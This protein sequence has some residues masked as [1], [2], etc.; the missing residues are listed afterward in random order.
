MLAMKIMQKGTL[1]QRWVRREISN[2]QYIMELNA[3][4]GRSLLD[5]SHYPVFPWVI[6]DFS[7]DELDLFDPRTFRDL[8][9]PMGA[10]TLIRL[11]ELK[12]RSENLLDDDE[13][14]DSTPY[15]LYGSHYSTPIGTVAHFL[16]R[17]DPWT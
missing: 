14:I 11:Q 13:S 9:R 3:L 10:L 12:A 7:S 8:Q 6:G 4:A 15:F 1:T 5:S 17:L 2:F 16:L